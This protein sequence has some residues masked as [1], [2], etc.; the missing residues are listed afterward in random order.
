MCVRRNVKLRKL[1]PHES[2]RFALI[3][4]ISF[5]VSTNGPT[6]YPISPPPLSF[7]NIQSHD[8]KVPP[9]RRAR[10]RHQYLALGANFEVKE[11]VKGKDNWV[12]SSRIG[13]TLVCVC[14][15]AIHRELKLPEYAIC[16]HYCSH[17][18][19]VHQC[20]HRLSSKSSS[21]LV[22]KHAITRKSP[23]KP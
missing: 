5:A 3:T 7:Q 16:A 17:G 9:G 6:G 4:A 12:L 10:V 11:R 15:T 22:P 13:P 20:A 8:E 21:P 23:R 14:Q 19:C 1:N 18:C 2:T